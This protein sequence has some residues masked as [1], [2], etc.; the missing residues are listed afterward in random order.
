MDRKEEKSL[1]QVAREAGRYDVEAYRFMFE[2]LDL[3]LKKLEE[4][5]HVSGAELSH[6]VRELAL[7]RFG[8]MARSVLSQWGV[9]KTQD[10]GEIV[11]Q[12]VNAGLMSKT[13][14]DKLSDFEDIY[15]FREAFDH[16]FRR[17]T[18]KDHKPKHPKG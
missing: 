9:H 16:A 1:E 12:L 6:A 15:D 17:R 5:R 2:A 11:F 4:R 10:F 13:E 7:E 3:L 14:E 18:H 8:F